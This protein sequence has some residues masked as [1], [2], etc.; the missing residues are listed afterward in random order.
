[1]RKITIL[2][3][4]GGTGKTATAVNLSAA[5]ALREVQHKGGPEGVFKK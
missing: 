1:M 5:L 4:N 3:F 2:N